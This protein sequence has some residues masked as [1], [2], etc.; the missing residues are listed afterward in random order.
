MS[1]DTPVTVCEYDGDCGDPAVVSVSFHR[2]DRTP[3]LRPM[4]VCEAHFN[5]LWSIAPTLAGWYDTE[6]HN[7]RQQ[8]LWSEDPYP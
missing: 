4:R 8:E 2:S 1:Q 5:R 7:L 3:L 6:I